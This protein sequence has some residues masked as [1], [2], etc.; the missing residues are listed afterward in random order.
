MK[1]QQ[2]KYLIAVRDHNLNVSVASDALY[3]SQPGVSKQIGLLESELGCASSSAAASTCTGSPRWGG[4]DHQV[5]RGHAQYREQDQGHLPGIPG[6]DRGH[7][8]HPHHPHHRPLPAAEKRHL[9]HQK[10]PQDLVPP[11]S[12]DVRHQGADQQGILGFFHRG[13]RDR[14]RQGADRAARLPL[15]LSLVV[16]QEHPW[17]R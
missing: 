15:D 1:L 4:G 11:A 7:P 10:V 17:P 2:L 3:T 14:L 8:Q 6:S 12:C 9:L 16:P 5:C 13:P